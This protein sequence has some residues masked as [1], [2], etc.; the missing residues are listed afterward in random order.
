MNKDNIS[1]DTFK[2]IVKM[3]IILG[4]ANPDKDEDTL[5]KVAVKQ[6]V[7]QMLDGE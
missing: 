4:Q 5:V 3:G 2:N 6:L 7:E 1:L